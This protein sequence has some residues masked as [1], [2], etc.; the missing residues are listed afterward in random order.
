MDYL[1]ISQDALLL[2]QKLP[3][4]KGKL[5]PEIGKLELICEV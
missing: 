5:W 2:L 1:P 4:F 3:L